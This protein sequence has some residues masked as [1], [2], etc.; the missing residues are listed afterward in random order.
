MKNKVVIITGGSS[1]IGKGCAEVFGQAG[2]KI[3]ITG[4]NEKN[5]NEAVQDLQKKNITALAVVA[6][7]SI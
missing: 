4:R 5:L 3:V 1:G 2:A 7:V 6:D